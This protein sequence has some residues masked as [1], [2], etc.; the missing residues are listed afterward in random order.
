MFWCFV[1]FRTPTIAGGL[2]AMSKEYFIQIGKYDEG[3]DIW[4]FEN[5]EISLRVSKSKH[6]KVGVLTRLFVFK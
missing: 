1:F 2:F 3:M 6:K 5:V 4:G